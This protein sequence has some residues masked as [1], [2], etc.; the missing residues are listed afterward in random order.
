MALPGLGF[1]YQSSRQEEQFFSASSKGE[2]LVAQ[3]VP[4]PPTAGFRRGGGGQEDTLQA[5]N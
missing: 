1:S 2:S 5:K 3:W 4:S